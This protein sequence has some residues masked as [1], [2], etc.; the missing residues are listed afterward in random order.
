LVTALAYL[1][2]IHLRLAGAKYERVALQVLIAA[3]V[4]LLITWIGV[5][6]LPSA[7]ASVHVY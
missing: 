2:Y 1:V 5:N 7:Q 3:F 6:Y 4:M